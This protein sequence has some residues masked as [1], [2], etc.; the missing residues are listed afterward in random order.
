MRV[1]LIHRNPNGGGKSIEMLFTQLSEELAK[2]IEIV[3]IF[4]R[5]WRKF[6]RFLCDIRSARADIFHIT[7]DVHYLGLLLPSRRTVHTVH[8]VD[9]YRKTLSGWR[10]WVYRWIWFSLTLPRAAAIVAVSKASADAICETLGLDSDR[11]CVIPNFVSPAFRPIPKSESDGVAVV[12]QVGTGSQKNILRLIDALTGMPCRLIL[13]GHLNDEQKNAV[14]SSGVPCT[15]LSDLTRQ[16][17]IEQYAACDIVAFASLYEGF[18]VPIVEAQIVGRPVVT[19]NRNPM[20]EVAGD[21]ALLIDPTDVAAYR[22]AIQRLINDVP[23]REELIAR[24]AKNAGRYSLDVTKAQYLKLYSQV[25]RFGS[26]HREE[27]FV[28]EESRT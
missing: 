25:L 11:I 14:A 12:L 28:E 1:A 2:E 15:C 24:G 20:S 19:S 7:G 10:K 18:G 6:P 13:I 22:A 23:F 16:E 4:W 27:N 5:G 8:D 26:S 21:G 17:I 3:D 9:H